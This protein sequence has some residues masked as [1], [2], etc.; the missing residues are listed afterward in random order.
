MI[1]KQ[2]IGINMKITKA[3]LEAK[4]FPHISPPENSLRKFEKY[5][6]LMAASIL[7]GGP[8][9]GQVFSVPNA[10]LQSYT[11][12]PNK[13]NV[14]IYVPT[15]RTEKDRWVFEWVEII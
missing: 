15:D 1:A 8:L 7:C 5:D 12:G 4:V 11:Q 3:E 14:E 13:E 9:N 6:R 2:E 10:P